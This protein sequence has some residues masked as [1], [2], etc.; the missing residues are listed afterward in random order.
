M[1]LPKVVPSFK[2]L[3]PRNSGPRHSGLLRVGA[4]EARGPQFRAPDVLGRGEDSVPSAVVLAQ[5]TCGSRILA[6]LVTMTTPALSPWQRTTFPHSIRAPLRSNRFLLFSAAIW[7]V[8]ATG[9]FWRP[10]RVRPDLMADLVSRPPIHSALVPLGSHPCH[11]ATTS[12]K[13][14]SSVAAR[15]S[16]V[17]PANSITPAPRL[18][19]R[20]V[21]RATK[22]C[23]STATRR[24]S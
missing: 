15:S 2:P 24:P 7:V 16:S 3:G 9:R 4:T 17:R 20:S 13:F 8:K 18:A 12:R 14:C 22:S 6:H 10:R 5:N 23:W 21:K 1:I 19:K 11:V